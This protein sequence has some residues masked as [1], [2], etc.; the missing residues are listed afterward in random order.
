M[1]QRSIEPGA[2]RCV[3]LGACLLVELGPG[4]LG[5]PACLSAWG[6]GVCLW[7]VVAVPAPGPAG[8]A[9]VSRR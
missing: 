7:L 4:C 8:W 5:W 9:Q 2:R 6:L 3:N 1:V